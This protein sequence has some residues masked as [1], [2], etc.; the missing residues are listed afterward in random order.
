MIVLSVSTPPV[1]IMS[2][3]YST[4]SLIA[5]F[6]APNELAQAASITQLIP[7]KFRRLAIRPATMLANIPGKAFSSHFTYA[8]LIFW[9]IFCVSSSEIPLLL[10]TFSQTGYSNLEAS[11]IPSCFAIATPK[12]TPTVSRLNSRDAP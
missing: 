6:K 12:I 4:S 9:T 5:I 3:R 8:L 2:D 1:S 11:G 10:R 7:P